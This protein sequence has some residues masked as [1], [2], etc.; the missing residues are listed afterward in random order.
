[1][2]LP[3]VA[4][5]VINVGIR[6]SLRD[7]MQIEPALIERWRVAT[8]PSRCP[9][10]IDRAAHPPSPFQLAARLGDTHRCSRR[11][12]GLPRIL[13]IATQPPPDTRVTLDAAAPPSSH[14]RQQL[15]DVA[16]E[17]AGIALVSRRM[18]RT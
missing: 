11:R 4:A 13:R 12:H 3:K 14:I 9:D 1:L 16:D 5:A 10:G 17:G 2:R 18:R 8:K 7:T 15:I 6:I